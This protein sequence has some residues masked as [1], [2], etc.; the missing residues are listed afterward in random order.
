MSEEFRFHWEWLAY[1]ELPPEEA[2]TFAELSIELN[3]KPAM[4]LQDIEAQTMRDGHFAAAYP[5]ALFLAENW[6]RIGW[7]PAP[8]TD[9]LRASPR[10][11]LAHS[12]AS[13]GAGFVWPNIMFYGDG[14]HVFV[15]VG[16][17]SSQSSSVQFVSQGYGAL[18]KET[19]QAE[20]QRF[21]KGVLARLQAR[22]M[23]D[24]EL[25]QVWQTVV[26]E[27]QDP[28]GSE[29]R[30]LEA[31]AGFDPGEA[32]E[33]F[34]DHLV[35]LE[36]RLGAAAIH[37]LVAASRDRTLNDV[38]ALEEAL[39]GQ[40]LPYQ[41]AESQRIGQMYTDWSASAGGRRQPPWRRAREAARMARGVW[42]VAE[43]PLD[44]KMLAEIANIAPEQLASA[45]VGRVPYSAALREPEGGHLVFR[46]RHEHG[47]RF[48]LGRLMG[49]MFYSPEGE[50][51]AAATHASTS[52]Q[53]FQRAFSQELLCP[54]ESLRNFLGVAEDM[55]EIDEQHLPDDDAIEEAAAHFH[56]SPMLIQGTLVN[57]NI[58]PH[59]ILGEE[60]DAPRGNSAA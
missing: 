5:V 46:T 48:A 29:I 17:H 55:D 44:N 9:L 23:P 35:S 58:L 49:D 33:D 56:V 24:S 1:P 28:E 31:L 22:E 12:M 54:F 37:E 59:G 14:E 60:P 57:H 10:W 43:T 26:D 40:G 34:L 41:V 16:P 52:R 6:W 19:F 21:I 25:E 20:V 42:G 18:P 7:E 53:K 3:G 27:I 15:R 45:E 50:K 39:K 8:A 13:A 32:A 11:R 36:N 4:R 47:R 2:A 51:L 38:E 30:R